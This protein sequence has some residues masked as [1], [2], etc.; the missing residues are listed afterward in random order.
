MFAVRVAGAGDAVERQLQIGLV[1]ILEGAGEFAILALDDLQ[2]GEALAGVRFLVI[3]G[4]GVEGD[5]EVGHVAH[6]AQ[7]ERVAAVVA[8]GEINAAFRVNQGVEYP[9][10][11]C[12]SGRAGGLRRRA[13]P[14]LPGRRQ[15]HDR[16]GQLQHPQRLFGR[17][18]QHHH[19]GAGRERD[20]RE[21]CIFT[22]APA[23]SLLSGKP[24]HQTH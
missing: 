24:M 21:P 12:Q 7:G 22:L 6:P 23:P 1:E 15:Q 11:E 20:Y 2:V 17:A 4:L 16:A 10:R 18:G 9:A 5:L 13:A 14:A 19:N 8:G 3:D